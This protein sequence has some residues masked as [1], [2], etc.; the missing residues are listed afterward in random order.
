M[1]VFGIVLK[2][3][4]MPVTEKLIVVPLGHSGLLVQALDIVIL[5]TS[6]KSDA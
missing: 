1:I 3:F 4:T 2:G 5:L 6:V